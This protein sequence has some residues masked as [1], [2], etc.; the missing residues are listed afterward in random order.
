MISVF[1]GGVS[2]GALGLLPEDEP[3]LH[4]AMHLP[5]TNSRHTS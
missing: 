4:L 3:F 2:A 1:R 5:M